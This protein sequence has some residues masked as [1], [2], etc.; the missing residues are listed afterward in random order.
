MTGRARQYALLLAGG[1]AV[2]AWAG[3]AYA[4]TWHAYGSHS[5]SANA[6]RAGHDLV[7]GNVALHGWRLP[8]DS[9]WSID[10][11]VFGILAALLGLGPRIVH[12]GPLLIAAAGIGLSLWTVAGRPAD[13]PAPA[14]R[15]R[16]WLI[17]AA[18]PVLLLGLPHAFLAYIFFQGPWHVGTAVLCLLAFNLAAAPLGHRRW[19]AAVAVLAAAVIGDPIA[20]AL[21]VAPVAGASLLQAWRTRRAGA[22]LHAVGSGV[23]P[24]VAAGLVRVALSAAGGFTVATT[25]TSPLSN[26]LANLRHVP[27]L[28]GALLGVGSLSGLAGG[29]PVPAGGVIGAAHWTGAAGVAAAVAVSSAG[30]LVA[31]L[32]REPD[33]DRWI[34]DVLV[35]GF[36]GSVAAYGIVAAPGAGFAGARYLPAPL[37][38][39]VT[40]AG[41]RLADLAAAA[42]ALLRPGRSARAVAVVA[43]VAAVAG[44]AGGSWRLLE[45]RAPTDPDDQLA[46]ALISRHLTFGY[47]PYWIA[48]NAVLHSGGRLTVIAVESVG[49]RLRPFDFYADRHALH[50]SPPEGATFVVFRADTGWGNVDGAAAAASFGPPG[51]T[52]TLGPYTLLTYPGPSAPSG[53]PELT[54]TRPG[55][56]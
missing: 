17:G 33:A 52:E 39:A 18:A 14:G 55:P 20:L 31:V 26:V 5:D 1:A 43:G 9:Y 6:A 51:G 3:F 22:V 24:V 41:R 2:V 47:A 46:A 38:F 13:G 4:L 23:A 29:A 11:P 19:W 15:Q 49:G 44:Y 34:D 53:P 42:P 32:R 35:L 8:A 37:L 10:L 48:G 54:A 36:W 12:L 40:L 56:G 27:R 16:A 50:R 7:T 25:E 45:H 30:T 28:L 21:G